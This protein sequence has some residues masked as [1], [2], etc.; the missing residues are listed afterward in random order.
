MSHVTCHVSRVTCHMSHVTCYM[1]HDI[2]NFFIFWQNGGASQWSV[3]YQ[4]G[5][6]RLVFW[7]SRLNTKHIFFERTKFKQ[8]PHKAKAFSS[9]EHIYNMFNIK[10]I[11]LSKKGK[12]KLVVKE[13]NVSWH[14]LSKSNGLGRPIWVCQSILG[15]PI[16]IFFSQFYSQLYSQFYFQVNSRFYSQF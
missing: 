10:H 3:C 6:P 14:K 4:R 15:R 8:H 13:L 12:T 2:F 7:C 16:P 1:S 9:S 11:H 5:L